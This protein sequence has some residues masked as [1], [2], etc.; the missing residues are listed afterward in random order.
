MSR[1]PG[2]S[3]ERA[4]SC[5]AGSYRQAASPI[6]RRPHQDARSRS[7]F[8]RHG[9]YRTS[10]AIDSCKCHRSPP[11]CRGGTRRIGGIVRTS[12]R[13][14]VIV[15]TG[16]GAVAVMMRGQGAEQL[17]EG[18][19]ENR[20]QLCNWSWMEARKHRP[21]REHAG[22]RFAFTSILDETIQKPFRRSDLLP[23]R[24]A[25]LRANCAVDEAL[26][27]VSKLVRAARNL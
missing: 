26:C 20:F 27:D 19:Y 4:S 22:I 18:A 25:D 23:L 21:P 13:G 16:G 17:P 10:A 24:P 12:G 3:K 8:R 6:A 14:G 5:F 7:T 2:P 11:L 15:S 1:S 9:A